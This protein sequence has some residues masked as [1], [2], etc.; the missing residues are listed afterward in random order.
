MS[1][2][3]RRRFRWTRP[4]AAGLDSGRRR[5]APARGR[6]VVEPIPASAPE[7]IRL[8]VVVPCYN[9]QET[10]GELHRRLGAAC[11][12]AAGDAYEIVLVNDGSRDATWPLMVDA[13]RR[14]PRI[15]AVNLAR[16]FGK[17]MALAAGL[18]STRGERV[19]II[20]ADLQDPPELIKD[21]MA[22]M[23]AG[24]D[25]VYGLRP[26]REGETWMKRFTSRL[27]YRVLGW[28][29][30][31]H[32]PA[33]TGDFRLMNRRVVDVLLAMPET[34]RYVRGLVSWAGMTQVPLP[35]RRPPRHG[36]K[37]KFTPGKLI[38]LAFDAVSAFSIR[39]LRIASYLGLVAGVGALLTLIYVL[40]SWLAGIAI[41]G[42]T[43]L[44]LVV[45]LLN[46]AQLIVIGIMGEYLGRTYLET[47]RR[48]LFVIQQVVRDGVA[49]TA[50]AL[51][52]G[53]GLGLSPA[54]PAGAPGS[55]A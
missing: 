25:V 52:A 50:D 16:N 22:K 31:I 53:V 28:L 41:E 13:A 39:P 3:A 2:A 20:D 45:L 4:A 1:G 34:H 15:V 26:E 33:D 19:A 8:S 49:S 51:P 10:L 14:D 29:S 46:S 47:K 21:M 18:A 23:D 30:D 7:R 55:R 37:T 27:F 11:A 42:W 35:Y 24:A 43:S 44:M 38:A 48:P 54:A 32:I 6:N 9:E 5:R 36:G 12:D 17:E 40:W